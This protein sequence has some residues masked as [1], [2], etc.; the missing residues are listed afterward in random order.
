MALKFVVWSTINGVSMYQVFHFV[1]CDRTCARLRQ[2]NVDSGRAE[3]TDF[4][5]IVC[6]SEAV[7]CGIILRKDQDVLWFDIVVKPRSSW[8][9]W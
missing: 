2:E 9:P 1:T 3:V 8:L 5:H 6:K 7:T 4:Q